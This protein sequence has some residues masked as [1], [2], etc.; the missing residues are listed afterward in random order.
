MHH[1][2]AALAPAFARFV[3]EQSGEELAIT[4]IRLRCPGPR[5]WVEFSNGDHVSAVLS[6]QDVFAFCERHSAWDFASFRAALLLEAVDAYRQVQGVHHVGS[7]RDIRTRFGERLQGFVRRM[8]QRRWPRRLVRGLRAACGLLAHT[9][10]LEAQE[11][12]VR[13]LKQTL[14]PAQRLQYGS[15]WCFD[16]TGGDS[17][18]RYRIRHGRSMNIDELDTRG[19]RVRGWCFHPR[20]DLVAED[21]M[22]AQKL[23]LELFESEALEVANR[24]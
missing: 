23:A 1:I 17:G 11:R 22:L 2:S 15:N 5:L 7:T 9:G 24:M 20:G 21:V 8:V 10:D 16:V 19:R 14:S 13:L 4:D 6:E 18:K 3:R 12:A